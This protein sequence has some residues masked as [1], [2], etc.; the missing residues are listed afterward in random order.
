MSTEMIHVDNFDPSFI[1]QTLLREFKKNNYT[2]KTCKFVY[3]ASDLLTL[4][5]P[6]HFYTMEYDNPLDVRLDFL[7]IMIPIIKKVLNESPLARF[8]GEIISAPQMIQLAML[9]KH[10][11]LQKL[12]LLLLDKSIN[13]IELEHVLIYGCVFALAIETIQSLQIFKK[14][15]VD[16]VTEIQMAKTWFSKKLRKNILKQF[17]SFIK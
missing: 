13:S 6:Y 9:P 10:I 3:Y 14:E 15:N 12:Q 8:I 16:L 2:I 4:I 17:S 11:M 5:H 1:L 7:E